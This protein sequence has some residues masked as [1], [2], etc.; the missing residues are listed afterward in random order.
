MSKKNIYL[1]QVGFAFDRSL[2]FPCAAG[3]IAAYAL[4]DDFVKNTYEFKEFI[5]KRDKLDTV[6]SGMEEPFLAGFSCCVWNFEYNKALAKKLK[7]ACPECIVVFGGHN[8]PDGSSL[9][10]EEDYIDILV[11]GE[12]EEPFLAL[13]KA[14][15]MVNLSSVPNIAYRE[16]SSIVETKKKDSSD[17]ENYPSPYLSGVF[18]RLIGENP[19]VEFLA[20]LETN[21]G[22]PFSCSYCDWCAGK[23]VRLFPMERIKAE[24][25]WMSD[26]KIV[27]LF[28]GHLKGF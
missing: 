7:T 17:I 12:G 25:Q 1:I 14:L 10:E 16:H 18:D 20:V 6:V 9:L 15:P 23:A 11:H 28:R 2:Y 27:K 19:D 8:I 3:A 13:L 24:I 5:F 26:K 22:C 4:E 21:R